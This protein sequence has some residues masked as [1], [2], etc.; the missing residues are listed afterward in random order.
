MMCLK[1]GIKL[2]GTNAEVTPGQWEFQVGPCVGIEGGDHHIMAR[3]IML[4]V[5]EKH[6]VVP[7][8]DPKPIAG[9]DWNGSG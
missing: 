2:S 1:A 3:Y 6:G 5:C 4:R 8:Y 9:L 7:N